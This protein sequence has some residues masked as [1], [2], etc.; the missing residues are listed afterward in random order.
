METCAKMPEWWKSTPCLIVFYRKIQKAGRGTYGYG[1]ILWHAWMRSVGCSSG[2]RT[3]HVSCVLCTVLD[4]AAEDIMH[5]LLQFIHLLNLLLS[6][7]LK[8]WWCLY[9]LISIT[10]PSPIIILIY[11]LPLTHLH[12]TFTFT[13]TFTFNFTF[14]FT[15]SFFLNLLLL[16]L[17]L[18]SLS[19]MQKLPVFTTSLSLCISLILSLLLHVCHYWLHT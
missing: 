3:H 10:R 12:F 9:P 14:T 17:H 15:C 19:S 13:Y 16:L 7:H 5:S 8:C 11:I 1:H 6:C 2:W 18:L 4:F